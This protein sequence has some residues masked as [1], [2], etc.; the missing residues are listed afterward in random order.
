MKTPIS[1]PPNMNPMT[2]HT[3]VSCLAWVNCSFSTS[4]LILFVLF[5]ITRS[6]IPTVRGFDYR[7]IQ[8]GTGNALISSLRAGRDIRS[9]MDILS[10]S[11]ASNVHLFHIQGGIIS[12]LLGEISFVQ[13]DGKLDTE[14]FN[15]CFSSIVVGISVTTI[16]PVI[17]WKVKHRKEY[18]KFVPTG[19]SEFRLDGVLPHSSHFKGRLKV[20]LNLV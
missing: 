13:G 6:M 3:R 15:S 11:I 20:N 8:I 16:R 19:P 9:V 5:H 2:I 12:R 14:R 18:L 17:Y 10:K 1:I 7:K 4:S